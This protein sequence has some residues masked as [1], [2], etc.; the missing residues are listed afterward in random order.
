MDKLTNYSALRKGSSEMKVQ[1]GPMGNCGGN[2][3]GS[4]KGELS[5]VTL[6]AFL[7]WRVIYRTWEGRNEVFKKNLISSSAGQI[8][9]FWSRVIAE[10]S[11]CTCDQGLTVNFITEGLSPYGFAFNGWLQFPWTSSSCFLKCWWSLSVSLV[12]FASHCLG[13]FSC[14]PIQF[15]LPCWWPLHLSSTPCLELP[16]THLTWTS[17]GCFLPRI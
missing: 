9:F 1:H 14:P 2:R 6:A 4:K 15:P 7:L 5:W 16:M 10:Q 8:L 17:H 3:E 13:N 11:T 12:H